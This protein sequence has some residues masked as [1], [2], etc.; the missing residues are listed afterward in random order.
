MTWPDSVFISGGNPH[1]KS[2][3]CGVVLGPTTISK[4]VSESLQ[5][6][7]GHLLSGFRYRATHRLCR[8]TKPN[9]YSFS[10]QGDSRSVASP[11]WKNQIKVKSLHHATTD[12]TYPHITNEQNGSA[13]NSTENFMGSNLS[14][15][16]ENVCYPDF[17]LSFLNETE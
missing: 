11:G 5:D 4:M 8:R 13:E 1:L 2:R 10:Q 12:M 17:F 15:I 9:S 14:K 3:F 7:L 6:S 16:P